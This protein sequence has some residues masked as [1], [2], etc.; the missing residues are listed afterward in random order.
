MSFSYG[1]KF[2][3]ETCCCF[4]FFFLK[5]VAC[6]KVMIDCAIKA[7]LIIEKC[8]FANQIH[9]SI[10]TWFFLILLCLWQLIFNPKI[11]CFDFIRHLKFAYCANMQVSNCFLTTLDLKRSFN[12]F[13]NGHQ[14]FKFQTANRFECL[15]STR[16]LQRT[17]AILNAISRLLSLGE[18]LI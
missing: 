6:L 15:K 11:N 1:D 14:K 2:Q 9:L 3:T 10:R 5:Q 7:I 8:T 16:P 17:A 12:D 13:R 18:K 4:S